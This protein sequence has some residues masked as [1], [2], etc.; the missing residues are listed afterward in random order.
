[1]FG[2]LFNNDINS[3]FLWFLWSVSKCVCLKYILKD[4]ITLKLCLN[5]QLDLEPTRQQDT[6]II[7]SISVF[8]PGA[9]VCADP[10]QVAP[11]VRWGVPGPGR[12]HG[13][14]DGSSAQGAQPVHT[15]VRAAGHLQNQDCECKTCYR[16]LM[17]SP[18]AFERIY[19][20]H[21]ICSLIFWRAAL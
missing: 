12:S 4:E 7:W 16:S 9:T 18:R 15:P 11:D 1:M 8:Q 5:I 20:L 3:V 17:F 21:W 13:L 10:S 6:A 2:I 19:S 14:W